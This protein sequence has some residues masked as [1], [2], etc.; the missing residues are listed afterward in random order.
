MN[1]SY[2]HYPIPAKP[3]FRLRLN[4]PSYPQM[5]ARLDRFVAVGILLGQVW[6]LFNKRLY[7]TKLAHLP[8]CS[9]ILDSLLSLLPR[10]PLDE[11]F[12]NE[13]D[14]TKEFF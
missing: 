11:G 10:L 2:L 5:D 7:S 13:L 4:D 9:A 6:I 8:L 3:A 12:T 1:L 14:S